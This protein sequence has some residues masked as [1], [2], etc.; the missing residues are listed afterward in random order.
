[1]ASPAKRKKKRSSPKTSRKPA[2]GIR[3]SVARMTL[4]RKLGQLLMV[5]V[6]GRFTSAE[7]PA[8][9]QLST[10]V[11]EGKVGGLLLQAQRTPRGIEIDQ[12][13]PTAALLNQLQSQAKIPLLV[14]ADFETGT[15]MRL[16][17]GTRLPHLMAIAATGDPSDARIAGKI[18]AI[19]ARVAG[20][21]WIFAPVAD[22]NNNPANPIINIRSFGEDPERVAELV[23]EFVR[24][25][26]SNGVLATA[27]H[28]PGH[29]DTDVDS[30][31][32]LPVISADR[33]RLD[34]AELVPFRAA[35]RAGVGSMMTGHLLV[36]S[37]EPDEALPATLSPKIIEDLLRREMGFNGLV[38]TDSLD[39]AG[40]AMLYPPNRTAVLSMEAGADVLLIPP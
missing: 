35:I 27:K 2:S 29:G 22:L 6:W 7:D 12:V 32:G 14:A 40:V 15:A 26:Q 3:Q 24:G 20:V 5:Y 4:D 11:A 25:A 31:V 23:A 18:T 8:F 34:R 37:L 1:M 19:E 9:R 33:V 17:E 36:P 28:F 21:N 10:W 30:H 38:V 39:M 13:Y 16:S